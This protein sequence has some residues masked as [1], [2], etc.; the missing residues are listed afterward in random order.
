MTVRGMTAAEMTDASESGRGRQTE[1]H[2]TRETAGIVTGQLL[3]L[4]AQ[5]QKYPCFY[6]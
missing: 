6:G 5:L 1:A 2:A 4:H 3:I